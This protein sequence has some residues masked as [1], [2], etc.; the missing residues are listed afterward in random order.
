MPQPAVICALYI[1]NAAV[2]QNAA[3]RPVLAANATPS[4]R[5][6]QAD[7]FFRIRSRECVGLRREK[8]LF[9]FP[10]LVSDF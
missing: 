5:T 10:I 1:P 2:G 7:F 9:S 4:F 3:R 6:E 8:S